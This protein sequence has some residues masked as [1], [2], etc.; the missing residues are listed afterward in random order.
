MNSSGRERVGGP[1]AGS[2][3]SDADRSPPVAGA[4]DVIA[5]SVGLLVY[6]YLSGLLIE[7][8]RLSS[9]GLPADLAPDIFGVARLLGT[10]LRAT[11]FGAGALTVFCTIAY[12]GGSPHWSRRGRQWHQLVL[13]GTDD[14]GAPLGETAI[15]ILAGTSTVAIAA[16]VALVPA[17]VADEHLTGLTWIV[18]LVWLVVFLVL[19]VALL[20]VGPDLWGRRLGSALWTL[21]AAGALF[22]SAPLGIVVLVTAFLGTFGRVLA[23]LDRPQ[24]IRDLVRSPLPWAILAAVLMMALG[25]AAMPPVSFPTAAIQTSAG[26]QRGG[27]L[28]RT[29]AGLYIATCRTSQTTATSTAAVVS[30][31]PDG[32][33]RS[34]TFAAQPYRFDS[35]KRPSLL[36]LAF[37]A[38]GGEG[39]T[40]TLLNA[41]LRDRA[42]TCDGA[43]TEGTSND[44]ALGSNVL[45]GP[46]PTGGRA[47]DGEPPIQQTAPPLIAEL[48]RRYQPTV[49][50][51][52]ADRNWP[53][54]LDAVLAERGSDGSSACLIRVVGDVP[55]RCPVTGADLAYS[56]ASSGD[57]LQLPTK[58]ELDSTPEGQFEAF[59]RGLAIEAGSPGRWLGKPAVLKPWSTA[60]VYFYLADPLNREAFPTQAIDK[61][62]PPQEIGLEYWFYYPYN[63]YPAIYR[64]KLIEDTPLAAESVNADRHQGDWEH[65]DVLLDPQTLQPEWLYLARHGFEGTFIRWANADL[66][67][68]HPVV[69]AAYGGH[70]SYEPGCGEQQRPRASALLTRLHLRTVL[71]DL[72]VC[73]SG[74][75][76]FP[77]TSTPL[78]DLASVPW[79]CWPGHFG[80][81]DFAERRT[82]E[83]P[84]FERDVIDKLA[85]VAGP[86][87]PLRQAENHG[88]CSRGAKAGEQTLLPTLR[89]AATP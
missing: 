9:A 74:R 51:T 5:F 16:L 70:P 64:K 68:G 49:L 41:D 17:R 3:R 55:P 86:E 10:G 76:G 77:A 18:V 11:L 42:Q 88:V 33:V 32:S 65:V 7:R 45:V 37:H 75:L 44:P 40:T 83:S 21:L 28:G 39:E 24:S 66:A 43:G 87:A 30:F 63:Y 50:V 4:L 89:R 6:V 46:G 8:V 1:A 60:Q 13:R 25:F 12:V 22:V 34:L 52:T 31:V 36:T 27:Y 53:V 80:E 14:R 57:Y 38:A 72:L 19:Y 73:G 54:S 85:L 79:G 67:E 84:E 69:Q 20:D 48:A 81:A 35:G 82:A 29:A 59:T 23:R 58:L 61:Q 2:E 78:V 15:R 62:V 71:T 56:R 26:A 47:V